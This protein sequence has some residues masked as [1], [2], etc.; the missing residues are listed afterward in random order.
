ML[1]RLVYLSG[2]AHR[3]FE[4]ICRLN[5]YSATL[6]WKRQTYMLNINRSELRAPNIVGVS[7]H[8]TSYVF[9]NIGVF[10]YIHIYRLYNILCRVDAFG[11]VGGV[12]TKRR[13]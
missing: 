9:F 3:N 12:K 1:E 4:L 7:I 8:V 10:I 13:C 6:I 11:S 5:F 2:Y